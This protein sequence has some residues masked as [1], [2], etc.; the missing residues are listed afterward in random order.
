MEMWAISE[1]GGCRMWISRKFIAEC[2]DVV[3]KKTVFEKIVEG[4]SRQEAETRA[5]VSCKRAAENPDN[6]KVTVT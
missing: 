3:K 6:V 4:F 2:I 1:K 5:V